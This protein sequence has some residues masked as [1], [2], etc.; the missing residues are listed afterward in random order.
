[1]ETS[2][3]IGA[4]DD[5]RAGRN[6]KKSELA[7]A[8]GLRPGNVRKIFS[9]SNPNVDL[10]TLY[11]LMNPLGLHLTCSEARDPLALIAFLDS[12]REER[13]LSCWQ[14]ADLVGTDSSNLKRMFASENPRPRLNLLLDLAEVLEVSMAVVRRHDAPTDSTLL[15]PVETRESASRRQAAPKQK[16]TSSGPKPEVTST[17]DADR[18]SV[19]RSRQASAPEDATQEVKAAR[20]ISEPEPKRSR[21]ATTESGEPVKAKRKKWPE[22]QEWSD[23]GPVDE[24]RSRARE[25]E[26]DWARTARTER[27][28]DDPPRAE[29][30]EWDVILDEPPRDDAEGSKTKWIL[31]A[32]GIFVL[33]LVFTASAVGAAALGNKLRDGERPGASKKPLHKDIGFWCALGSAALVVAGARYVKNDAAR[34]VL[35]AAGVGAATGAVAGAIAARRGRPFRPGALGLTRV[36]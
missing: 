26:R 2:E 7:R 11:R 1:M 22:R 34:Q 25:H 5:H 27:S 20:R 17:P 14:L 18:D 8:A 15:Q 3:I 21:N 29:T 31:T 12:V 6:I 9:K 4:I 35:T 23:T 32:G 28:G 30:V 10:V 33:V 19:A 16:P 36:W 24:D 13:G